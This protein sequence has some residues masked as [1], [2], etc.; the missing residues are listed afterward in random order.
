MITQSPQEHKPMTKKLTPKQKAANK[1]KGI[2][3]GQPTRYKKQFAV[4][5]YKLCQLG[6]IDTD[7]SNFFNVGIKT[8]FNWKKAHPEFLQALKQSKTDLNNQV[9]KSLFNRAMGYSHPE[10]KFMNVDGEI[11]E[12]ETTK[13]YPPDPTSLIFWLKNREPEDWRDTQAIEVTEVP[14]VRRTVKRFDGS[15]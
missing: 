12:I 14:L 9:V 1:A 8:I 2:S 15:E 4:E 6:A 7:L 11:Q 5:A 13:H 3:A 10:S